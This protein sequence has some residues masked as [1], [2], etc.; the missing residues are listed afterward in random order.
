M[1]N[2][3][4]E[5]LLA[6]LAPA[7]SV[8]LLKNW[9]RQMLKSLA[10]CAASDHTESGTH[11]NVWL[12]YWFRLCRLRLDVAI[13]YMRRH[14]AKRL[15][16]KFGA[17]SGQISPDQTRSNQISPDQPRSAQIN[18]DQP[19]PTQIS[20]EQTRADQIREDQVISAQIHLDHPASGQ[21]SADQARSSQAQI[22]LH[23][24]IYI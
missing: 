17:R 6:F 9:Q 2:R 16:Q 11:C 24:Y 7:A 22:S 21:I 18:R 3:V 10:V 12:C 8:T 13:M 20:P 19:R 5:L 15:F 1:Q 14:V 4:N 23:I